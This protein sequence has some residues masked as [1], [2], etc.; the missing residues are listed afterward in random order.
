MKALQ[1]AKDSS[2]KLN[3]KLIE[4][5][6]ND[7]LNEAEH[8]DI[9]GIILKPEHKNPISRYNIDRITLTV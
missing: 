7:S 1:I 4:T 6:I 9:P 8:M 2:N 3:T 5:W